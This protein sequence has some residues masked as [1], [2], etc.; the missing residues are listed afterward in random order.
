MG[1]TRLAHARV[2]VTGAAGF[3]GSHLTDALLS[4]GAEVVG[5]DNLLTGSLDNLAHL[6]REDRF[7]LLEHDVTGHIEVEGRVDL[8]LHAASPASPVDY[9]QLPIQTLKVGS[10]GTHNALGLAKDNRAAFL[11]FSTS[12]VYGDPDVH[13]QP[14][15]YRGN[16][17]P[18]GPRGVY[19]EAKR[20]AEALTFAYHRTHG[21][22]VH[23]VRIFN[24][25]GPRMRMEDGRAVPNFVRQALAGE[26]LAVHGDGQ[27]TRSLCYV[28]DL[29][30]GM[31]AVLE[32]GVRGPINLGSRHEVTITQLADAVMDAV[33]VH[34]GIVHVD[35]PVDDPE[36]RCPDTSL[37]RELLGWEAHMTLAEGL[38]RTV[39][40]YRRAA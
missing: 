7:R 1:G 6:T 19:D 15:T 17:D 31:L 28:D 10:L 30:A 36:V 34:P 4:A 3:L 21:V 14:E 23:V 2:V 18:V 32:H 33:G 40:W 29:I 39:A 13:P 35:R 22:P 11:L 25:Y 8:V 27:Q 5:I 12:E 20:F 38:E 37:A 9:L 16:V 26:P 24:T